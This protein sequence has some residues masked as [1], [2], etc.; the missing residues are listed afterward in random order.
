MTI[1]AHFDSEGYPIHKALLWGGLDTTNYTV[2][3]LLANGIFNGAWKE[4]S[5]WTEMVLV[6][7]S[8]IASA[9]NGLWVIWSHNAGVTEDTL[10]RDTLDCPVTAAN[11]PNRFII[12]RKAR[13][14]RIIYYNSALDQTRLTIYSDWSTMPAIGGGIGSSMGVAPSTPGA[15]VSVAVA[16]NVAVNIATCQLG[17]R[18][19]VSI[20]G[21]E[22]VCIRCDAVN[23]VT[24]NEPWRDGQKFEFK[25]ITASGVTVRAIK[26]VAGSANLTIVVTALDGGA[27]A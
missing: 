20:E 13:Y 24:T 2:T 1:P 19:R 9:A 15:S 3:P 7:S 5:D 26:R 4:V 12:A 22:G 6:Q 27:I 8:D 25:C 23:P 18:Y 14:Y 21:G 16:V 10:L 17:K 11:Q